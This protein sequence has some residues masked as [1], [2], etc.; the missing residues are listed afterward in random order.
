MSR[1]YELN[2]SSGSWRILADGLG[3]SGYTLDQCTC[4]S[5]RGMSA[6]MGGYMIFTNGFDPPMIYFAGDEATG[7]DLHALQPISDLVALGITQAGGVV[8]WKGFVIIFDIIENGE[9]MGG[10]VVWSDLESPDSFIESDTSFAGRATIAVGATILNAAPLGNS[11]IFYTD[12]GIIKCTLVGGEDIFN[13]ETL[14]EGGNAMKYKFSLINAGDQHLFAGESD[15][16]MLSQF[17]SR[18]INVPFITKAAGMMFAGITEDHA[19]YDPVN[20]DACNLVTGGWSDE[21]KEG[22]LSWP[23]GDAICPN[24]TLRFNLKYG[25]ADFIDHGFTAFLTFRRDIRPTIGQWLEDLGVCERGEVVDMGVKDGDICPGSVDAVENPPLYI[26]NETENPELPNH[27][28]SLCALLEGKTMEDFC[29]ECPTDTTFIAAS[30]EDFAL[31]Q[32]EDDIY[33][34]EQ[35]GGGPYDYESYSCQGEF[36]HHVGYQ[37]VMQEGAEMYRVDQEKMIKA[38]IVEAEPLPQSTPSIITSEVGYAS[39]PNCFRWR[40]TKDLEFECQTERSESQHDTAKSRQDGTFYFPC[41]RRG[42]YISARF[43]IDG[44]GGGGTFTSLTSL[45]KTWGDP[46]NP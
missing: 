24:V 36:Y 30:A 29:S 17:D 13:F 14:Y 10:T 11:L 45:V 28:R 5:V 37:T 40:E 34:R 16:Y 27:P 44:I 39:T 1:V 19:A 7:C 21:T 22:F 6:T 33:Y 26:F 43:I 2:Q 9:R 32:L 18:P 3:N 15:V 41:W 46:E 42:R 8:V 12:K 31:K 4:N 20:R 38:I 25:T 23:S 35:L